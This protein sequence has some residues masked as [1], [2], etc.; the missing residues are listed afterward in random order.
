MEFSCY[1]IKE[2]VFEMNLEK[3]V[4]LLSNLCGCIAWVLQTETSRVRPHKMLP[5]S[6]NPSDNCK[7][8]PL[9][10]PRL[11]CFALFKSWHRHPQFQHIILK[12]LVYTVTRILKKGYDVSVS[13]YIVIPFGKL[14]RG[15]PD[16]TRNSGHSA[17]P[18]KKRTGTCFLGNFKHVKI[19]RIEG[20]VLVLWGVYKVGPLLHIH[21][22]IT[23]RSRVITQV[24][25]L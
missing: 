16:S 13:K 15:A 21:G 22:V 19:H 25:H 1:D 9:R 12:Y 6:N 5:S 11:S 23:P 14:Y 17:R 7:D 24:T 20:S 8:A 10:L 3:T 4:D 18:R 2:L